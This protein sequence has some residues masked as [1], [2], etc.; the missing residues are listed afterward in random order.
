[1]NDVIIPTDADIFWAVIWLLV[2]IAVMAF[3]QWWVDE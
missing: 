2:L 3:G 1:M